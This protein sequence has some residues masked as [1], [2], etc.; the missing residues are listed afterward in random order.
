MPTFL[1][2]VEVPDQCFLQEAL[3]W[4][5]FQRLP[6]AVYTLEGQD[7]RT[8][9]EVGG[10]EIDFVDHT[11]SNAETDRLGIPIDPRWPVHPDEQVTLPI[12]FFDEC[13]ASGDLDPVRRERLQEKRKNA[14]EYQRDCNAWRIHYDRAIEYSASRIFVALKSGALQARGRLLPALGVEQAIAALRA[15]GRDVYSLVPSVIPAAFWS[16]QGMDF[17]ASAAKNESHHY[18]HVSFRTEDV[19][20]VFPGEREEVSGVERIGDVFVLSKKMPIKSR[21]HRGRPPYPWDA[22]HLELAG[23][24]LRDALPKKK[25]AAIQHFQ[26]W[27]LTRHGV[28]ASRSAVGEKLKPYYDRFMKSDGQK[29]G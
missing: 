23:L 26:S 17:N 2:P 11:L 21:S 9:T 13:L 15:S 27:F 22:F 5:A 14:E 24:I 6:A 20:A 7:F 8:S 19:F 25:E 18:C 10:Y 28:S 29:S 1:E 12:E 3:F 4:V 16:L